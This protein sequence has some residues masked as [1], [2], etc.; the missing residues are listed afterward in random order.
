[1]TTYKAFSGLKTIRIK[2]HLGLLS[3]YIT[4][5]G[6]SIYWIQNY[7]H[8]SKNV[9]AP[10]VRPYTEQMRNLPTMV[11]SVWTNMTAYNSFLFLFPVLDNTMIRINRNSITQNHENHVNTV[12]QCFTLIYWISWW[13]VIEICSNIRDICICLWFMQLFEVCAHIRDIHIFLVFLAN[14][15]VNNKQNIEIILKYFSLLID[16]LFK[17]LQKWNLIF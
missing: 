16:R 5:E 14:L 3:S 8:D 1:M 6:P 11:T 10:T 17:Y 12:K 2:P 13:W 4:I 7:D 9:Y 15:N